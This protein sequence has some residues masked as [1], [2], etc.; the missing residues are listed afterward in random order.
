MKCFN[1]IA[2]SAALM[3][4]STAGAKDLDTTTLKNKLKAWQPAAVILNG[5]QI[6]IVTPGENINP[7]T[8]SAIISG[9]V[10]GPIW[11]NDT[12]VGYLKTIKQINVINKFKAIGYS[13][14]NPLSVCKE[15]GNLQE[16]PASA[17]M[18]GNTHTYKAK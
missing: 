1:V 5:N 8:Y 12:P 7:D 3:F 11:T 4:A 17:V 13:F 10:C 16:K 14:E 15:M 6:T 18:L 2:L 9:G